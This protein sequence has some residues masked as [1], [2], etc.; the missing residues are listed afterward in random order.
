MVCLYFFTVFFIFLFNCR[1]LSLTVVERLKKIKQENKTGLHI[2]VYILM[3][4]VKNDVKEENRR[5][6]I[7]N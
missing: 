7:K 2:N 5:K 1:S 3:F 4:Y 6:Y